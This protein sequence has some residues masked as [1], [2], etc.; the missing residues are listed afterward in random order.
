MDE[1]D[2][3]Q[4]PEEQLDPRI[5]VSQSSINKNLV[6]KCSDT[7]VKKIQTRTTQFRW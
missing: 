4:L 3:G 7:C 6:R 2:S 1:S 5:Q